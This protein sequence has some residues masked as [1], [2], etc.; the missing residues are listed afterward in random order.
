MHPKPY[1]YVTPA[2]QL[3]RE[4]ARAKKL[5]KYARTEL[6]LC[7]QL[8]SLDDELADTAGA[9]ELYHARLSGADPASYLGADADPAPITAR[10]GAAEVTTSNRN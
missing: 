2:T 7:R 1:R 5:L 4:I 6:M 8:V 3:K 10:H 9:V